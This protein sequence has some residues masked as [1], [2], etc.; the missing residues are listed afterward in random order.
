VTDFPVPAILS[1]ACLWL[2]G[3]LSIAGILSSGFR[4]NWLQWTG[5]AGLAVWSFGRASV[6]EDRETVNLYQFV[7]H[8]SLV[9]YGLGTA[10]E[11]WRRRRRAWRD[12]E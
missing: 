7:V 6:L 5:M 8:L 9:V 4:E 12:T 2:I 3:L 1:V 10:L 11:V